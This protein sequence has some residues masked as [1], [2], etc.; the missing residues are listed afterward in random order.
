MNLREYAAA[1]VQE[2]I[3]PAAPPA[4]L[5]IKQTHDNEATERARAVYAEYQENIKKSQSLQTEILKGI[6]AGDKPAAL[7]VKAA[8]CITA[9]TGNKLFADQVHRDIVEMYGGIFQEQGALEIELQEVNQR[10][11]RLRQAQGANVR[12]AIKEHEERARQIALLLQAKQ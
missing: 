5:V 3:T 10:L 6:Q 4:A 7:L 11:E 1:A 2:D 9:M 8:E 12:T